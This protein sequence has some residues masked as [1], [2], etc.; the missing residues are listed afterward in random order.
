MDRDEID[1]RIELLKRWI[2]TA[3]R[4]LATFYRPDK[5]VFWRDN[6]WAKN[7]E[8]SSAT[9]GSAEPK[10]KLSPTSTAR[11]FFAICE[12]IRFI[13]EEE[14][15]PLQSDF[16]N[17][18]NNSINILNGVASKFLTRLK[19]ERNVVIRSQTNDI[20]AFTNSH[21][22]LAVSVL[23]QFSAFFKDAVDVAGIITS[24]ET[25][26]TELV[27]ILE[28]ESKG[29]KPTSSEFDVVHDF[30]TLHSVRALDA[31]RKVRLARN[32]ELSLHL[33][34][35]QRLLRLLAYDFSH[36][37]SKFDAGELAFSTELL[38][39][40]QA[41]NVDQLTARSLRSI[42]DAQKGGVWPSGTI[43]SY[44]TKGSLYV[45]SFEIALTL[46]Q[47]LTR[48]LVNGD[49][50]DC[51]TLGQVLDSS[52]EFVR[53]S[54]SRRE[55]HDGWANDHARGR[56]LLESWTTSIVLEFLIQYLRASLYIRQHR[57]LQRYEVKRFISPE[58]RE[59]HHS[60]PDLAGNLRLDSW[61][62]PLDAPTDPTARKELTEGLEEAFI[63]PI[64]S[65]LVHR[66]RRTAS[67]ILYG[68]PGTGKSSLVKSVAKALGWP[69]VT[70]SPPDFLVKGIEGFEATAAGIFADLLILRRCLVLFDE[71]EDLFRYRPQ[72]PTIESRT[73]GA[74]ITAGMLPRLQ[75]LRE[76]S[77]IIF[78]LATNSRL[79][80]LDRAV[81]R[82]G[83]F[84]FAYEVPFPSLEASVRFV[85]MLLTKQFSKELLEK[86]VG[87]AQ[88]ALQKYFESEQHT[89][90]EGL[91]FALLKSFVH[92][93]TESTTMTKDA[94]VD[95]LERLKSGP[96]SLLPLP[97]SGPVS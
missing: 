63:Q 26:A 48:K 58:E 57:I 41:E 33:Q 91:S 47:T 44:G 52:F 88:E 70:I 71:C 56:G 66:P 27:K 37:N 15:D 73:A 67:I 81:I 68:S 39:R 13:S 25:I 74:F 87:R 60:F 64:R 28:G 79:D 6:A 45:S 72:T 8:T 59:W 4:A 30:L 24:T 55:P 19:N 62:S 17:D 40:F 97:K 54:Y 31:F 12:Y 18:F 61:I 14:L 75:A 38:N 1:A 20:N 65:D 96:R 86:H 42:A 21:V 89:D 10:Y 22:V 34:V 11:S 83:R 90:S 43:V 77:W 5:G 2:H 53:N 16:R 78:V 35:K 76:G 50:A 29:V 82:P 84:D 80:E 7:E 95:E 93:L 32:T 85:R 3:S 51:D 69:L 94:L 46:A 36:V 23:P 92:S 49:F 9:D